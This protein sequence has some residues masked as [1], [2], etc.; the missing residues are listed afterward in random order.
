MTPTMPTT[1]LP[2]SDSLVLRSGVDVVDIARIARLL[3]EFDR[4]FEDRVFTPTEQ[5][6]CDRRPDPAQHYAARWAAKEAFRK[7]VATEGP[8]VPFDAVSVARTAD[9]PTLALAA[10]AEE[11]LAH[12]LRRE[13][14][15]AE[16]AA[17]SVSL[18]HDQP[19]GV[20]VAHVVI[21]GQDAAGEEG[22]VADENREDEA[23]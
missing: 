11:A 4:A 21:A 23:E 2:H 19:A 18:A 3:D 7:A 10:P 5:A 13:G 9:G 12:T 14:V 17:T 6:Y 8:S 20:A 22:P 1:R 15:S 16:R